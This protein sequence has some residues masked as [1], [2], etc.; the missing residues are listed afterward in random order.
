MSKNNGSDSKQDAII[1]ATLARRKNIADWRAGQ[2]AEIDLPS[3][4]H[5]TLRNVTMT[6]LMLTGKL[7]S[8]FVE[9]ADEANKNGASSF[10]LK[11]LAENS[12]EFGLMLDALVQL[13]VISPVIGDV[14][15]EDN[16]TLAEI[17]N[18]DKMAIFNFVNREA[19]KLKSFRDGENE[20]RKDS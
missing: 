19:E 5:V 1:Q 9:M 17:P 14:A 20:P 13:A 6:D 15:D 3:G 2:R 4:L 18:D 10:D 8:V 7:P 12:K 16:I 11:M